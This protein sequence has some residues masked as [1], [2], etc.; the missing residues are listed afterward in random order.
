M[1]W[2]SDCIVFERSIC[3]CHKACIER[4]DRGTSDPLF[5]S[6]FHTYG[7]GVSVVSEL[8]FLALCIFYFSIF[9]QSPTFQISHIIHSFFCT[10]VC[11]FLSLWLCA[12]HTMFSFFSFQLF[13]FSFFLFPSPTPYPSFLFP[14]F[15][16]LSLFFLPLPPSFLRAQ[17]TKHTWQSN[18]YLR[19]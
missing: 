8:W 18:T 12:F 13:I 15:P 3:V 2:L 10:I 19:R 11:I 4:Q 7:T 9:S 5:S 6:S 1:G 14:P 16:P 17:I